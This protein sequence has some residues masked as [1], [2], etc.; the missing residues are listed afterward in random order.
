MSQLAKELD[1]IDSSYTATQPEFNE[2]V[3]DPI[4]DQELAAAVRHSGVEHSNELKKMLRHKVP[5]LFVVEFLGAPE[6][7]TTLPTRSDIAQRWLNP[8]SRAGYQSGVKE[9]LFYALLIVFVV[10]VLSAV[11]F[12][13]LVEGLF[14]MWSVIGLLT[15]AV[16]TVIADVSSWWRLRASITHLG[17][18]ATLGNPLAE[19]VREKIAPHKDARKSLSHIEPSQAHLLAHWSNYELR[20]ILSTQGVVRKQLLYSV[21]P[22]FIQMQ[23][24]WATHSSYPA[25]LMRMLWEMLPWAWKRQIKVL[26]ARLP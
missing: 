14:G 15:I 8:H 9:R 13:V 20:A 19:K 2:I 18:V 12:S 24:R 5:L 3:S 21:P 11:A 17:A 22:T 25:Y 1:K 10:A 4:L 6:K 23:Q 16:F 26:H 7:S